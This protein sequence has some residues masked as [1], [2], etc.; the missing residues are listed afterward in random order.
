M[1]RCESRAF[2]VDKSAIFYFAENARMRMN[3]DHVASSHFVLEE[4]FLASLIIGHWQYVC[5]QQRYARIVK[6]LYL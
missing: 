1:L 6:L 4:T 2:P 5:L 3:L